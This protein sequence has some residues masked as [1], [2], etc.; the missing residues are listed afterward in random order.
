MVSFAILRSS[1]SSRNPPSGASHAPRDI[2]PSAEIPPAGSLPPPAEAWP[3]TPPAR[4]SACMPTHHHRASLERRRQRDS[5]ARI[6][7]ITTPISHA[8]PKLDNAVIHNVA[9]VRG[10]QPIFPALASPPHQAGH[11]DYFLPAREK[12]SS[13]PSFHLFDLRICVS[14][15]AFASAGVPFFANTRNCHATLIVVDAVVSDAGLS[16]R[17]F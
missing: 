6:T 4:S 14:S 1:L 2:P 13:L 11:F 5:L 16:R 7:R 3:P 15:N 9:P 17:S 8:I 12:A 10:S